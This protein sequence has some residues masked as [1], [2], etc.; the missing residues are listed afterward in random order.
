MRLLIAIDL[1]DDDLTEAYGISPADGLG[2]GHEW[3]DM[4]ASLAVRLEEA[5]YF[6]RDNHPVRGHLMS[7]CDVSGEHALG[8]LLKAASEGA[9]TIDTDERRNHIYGSLITFREMSDA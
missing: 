1:N 7:A 8:D 9:W 5:G 2:M 3:G 6:G 4:L